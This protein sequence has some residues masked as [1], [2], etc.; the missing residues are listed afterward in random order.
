MNSLRAGVE[1][2]M[3]VPSGQLG[4]LLAV[5]EGLEHVIDGILQEKHNAIPGWERCAYECH[6]AHLGDF[7]LGKLAF[8]LVDLVVSSDPNIPVVLG[9][10]EAV[11]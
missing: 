2:R 3:S 6:N 7:Q 1:E 10:I 5:L 9:D 11:E 8:E 4:V